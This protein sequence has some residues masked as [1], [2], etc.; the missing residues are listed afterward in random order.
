V[1]DISLPLSATTAKIYA[2]PQRRLKIVAGEECPR[3]NGSVAQGIKN[4]SE[5][6]FARR[7]HF[8]E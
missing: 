7:T 3:T 8:N 4:R 5:V 6:A 2:G 1:P